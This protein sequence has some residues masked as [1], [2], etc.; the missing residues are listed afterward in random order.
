M[1]RLNKIG[2]VWN[3]LDYEWEIALNHLKA[4]ANEFGD[5]LVPAT[6]VNKEKFKLGEWVTIQRFHRQKLSLERVEKLNLEG[7]VWDAMSARKLKRFDFC[8]KKYS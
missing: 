5:T 2:F 3:V 8:N 4:Y 1:A 6:F 7:F